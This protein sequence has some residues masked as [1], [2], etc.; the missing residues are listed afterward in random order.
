MAKRSV[1]RRK[2][3]LEDHVTIEQ[4]RAAI[5]RYQ[6]VPGGG[7]ARPTHPFVGDTPQQTIRTCS[8]VLLFLQDA[9][10]HEVTSTGEDIYVAVYLAL[11]Y[12]AEVLDAIGQEAGVLR[13]RRVAEGEGAVKEART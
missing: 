12:A 7:M 1:A 9:H 4:Q 2:A 3:P 6:R 8:I 11:D 5:E 13:R 10:E